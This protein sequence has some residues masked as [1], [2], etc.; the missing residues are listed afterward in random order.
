MTE[1]MI[2]KIKPEFNIFAR[3]F[4]ENFFIVI[5]LAFIVMIFASEILDPIIKNIN[6]AYFFIYTFVGIT[7]LMLFLD[8]MN[9]KETCYFVYE[10]RIDFEEG[11]IN[12]KNTTINMKDIRE[13]HFNQTF[14]QRLM[15]L[16]TINFITAANNSSS[17]SG[18]KFKDI[19]NSKSVYDEIKR[20]YENQNQNQN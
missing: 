16:G 8:L 19:K 7:L 5:Y 4:S 11:F 6:P 12:H 15:G 20:L 18:V 3:L 13:I 2:F 9:Y 1:N 17:C 14:I 10:N